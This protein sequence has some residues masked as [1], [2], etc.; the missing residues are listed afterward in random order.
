LRKNSLDPILK[1]REGGIVLFDD[2]DKAPYARVVHDYLSYYSCRYF[3]LQAYTLDEFGRYSVLV[4]DIH[5]NI[6]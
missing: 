1:L 5:R 4:S 3:D 6:L 2:M